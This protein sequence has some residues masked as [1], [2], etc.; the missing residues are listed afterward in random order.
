MRLGLIG[1]LLVVD[2]AGRQVPLPVRLR[3]LLAALLVHA[4]QAVALEELVEIVWDG[5]PPG[6]AKR[7]VRSYVVRLRR[8]LGPGAGVRIETRD[9]GYLCRVGEDE[10]DV[11]RFEALCREAGTAVRA[12]GWARACDAAAAALAL[13]RGAPLLDVSSQVLRDQCVPRLEQL[14]LQVLEDEAQAQ[15]Q[16]GWHERLVPRLRELTGAH[17][18][19]E[20]FHAQLMLALAAGGRR[21]EAL[22]A[23]QQARRVLVREVGV[24]PGPELRAIHERILAGQEPRQTAKPA[25]HK[26]HAHA[27]E[28][29]AVPRQLPA[30]PGHFFGRRAELDLLSGLPDGSE[31]VAGGTVV[32]CAVDGMAGIGKTALA[33]H[34]GH[35]LAERFPDGQLFLDLHGYTKGYPP[36]EPGDALVVLLHGLGVPL[37]QVPADVDARAALYRQHLAGTRTLIVLDNAVG[38]TQVR[39]LLPGTPGCLVLVTSRRRL[40]GLDDARSLSLD[41]LPLPDAVALLRAVAGPDRIP[42]DDPLLGEIAQQCGSLPLALRIAGA[43][44]RHRPAWD[45][46]Y[47]AALLRDQHQRMPAL[48]DGERDLAT[49]LDL[50]YTGLGERHRLLLRRLGLVPGPDADAYAAAALLE[51]DPATATGLLEDLVDHNL[52]IA[53]AP[54]RYRLHDL[55]RAHARTLAVADPQPELAAALDRLLRYYAHTAQSASQ[56]IVRYRRPAPAGPAPAHSPALSDPEAAWA[57]L[58]AERETLEAAHAHARTLDLDEHIIALAAGLAEILRADGP[59]TRALDQQQA[60]AQTAER[61][62]QRAAHA[63][64]LADLGNVR[65]LAGDLPGACA[66]LTQAL[67]IFREV[68]NRDGEAGALAELGVVRSATRDVSGADAALNGAVVI[69]RETGNRD[70]VAYSLTE[71]GKTR[72]LAG[73][74]PEA[75]AALTEALK[76]YDAA[77]NR[78]GQAYV[79]IELGRLRQ[80]TGDL[81]GADAALTEALKIFDAAGNRSGQAHVLAELGRL[82]Q[83][84]G[85]LRGADAALSRTQEIFHESG[86]YH[87]EAFVLADLG[88]VRQSAGDLPGADDALTRA[89]TIFRETGNLHGEAY[90]LT[91]LGHLRQ[92][93]G[94]LPGADDAFIRALTIFRETGNRNNEGWALNEYAATIAASGDLARALALYRQALAMN[95]EL[96][97]PDDEACALEGLGLCHLSAGETQTGTTRLRQA[98]EIFQRLG[99]APDA[100]RVRDRLD[101]LATR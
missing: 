6:E 96:N 36:R 101:G 49:V 47:L 84:T 75:D 88:R 23:Y 25:A 21:A 74:L 60:A 37:Q 67:E 11:L 64:A 27:P 53:H 54:G 19:R 4:N 44:L 77:G 100:E 10:L 18:L 83:R 48:S 94:D 17:P 98:L 14:R 79:L 51:A 80:R 16:L 81:R 52:L 26:A 97:K 31:T 69:F 12:S 87:G 57:W 56:P 61:L 92:L 82:R 76:I 20:R 46:E 13:W 3:T 42:A 45:L 15:L 41:L 70:G 22:E 99:M 65:R 71:L 28:A 7:T 89:L 86:H 38:E 8:A 59:F 72:Q 24:E 39:P 63:T 35:R 55:I 95:R 68:G 90:A 58:R 2:D 50:S 32:I 93:A 34:A 73:D 5:A 30:A 33:V 66:A 1:S 40:K 78:S 85:D 43:L 29:G 9:P 62:G 91:G